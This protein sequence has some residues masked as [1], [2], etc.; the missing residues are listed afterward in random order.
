MRRPSRGRAFLAILLC[1]PVL[2]AAERIP[3]RVDPGVWDAP[4]E[5][6]LR[7]L[8]SAAEAF[9]APWP[10][11]RLP[12]V[13]VGRHDG[14]PIVLHQRGTNG[15]YR[16]LLNTG[17]TYWAQYAFQFAHELAHIHCNG[18]PGEPRPQGW[19]EE[20]ICETASLFVLRRMSEAWEKDPPYPN[21]RDFAP[22][23]RTYADE[24]ILPN[25]LPA[26]VPLAAFFRER[27]ARFVAG[28][29][30]RDEYVTV[31]AELL[32]AFEAEPPFW[33]AIAYLNT[34]ASHAGQTFEECLA[35]WHYFAPDAFK[36]AI[37]RLA[38]RFE[39]ALPH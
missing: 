33:V 12:P 24:R 11:R 28:G 17:R 7:V 22:A 4:D 15:S 5:N 16:V 37:R 30:T 26:G 27:A 18:H 13:E 3:I 19:F 25:R 31:A 20:V 38:A 36:D 2:L 6:V 10:D 34:A 21:W 8:E 35:Q 23:L 9:A 1:A 29:G 39:V 32:P 14:N